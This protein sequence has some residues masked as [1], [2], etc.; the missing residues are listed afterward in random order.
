MPR[1]LIYGEFVYRILISSFVAAG[2]DLGLP[3]RQAGGTHEHK[4]EGI[5]V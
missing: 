2:W 4:P 1:E 3:F 5:I